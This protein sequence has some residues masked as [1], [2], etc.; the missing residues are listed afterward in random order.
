MMFALFVLLGL[1]IIIISVSENRDALRRLEA[2]AATQQD[3]EAMEKR[4]AFTL[5]QFESDMATALA[6]ITAGITALQN[7]TTSTLSAADQATLQAL[8]TQTQA[9]AAQFPAPA[10]APAPTPAAS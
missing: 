4:M 6:A 10:P 9:L 2:N 1:Y 3:L 7:S 5:S 8:D